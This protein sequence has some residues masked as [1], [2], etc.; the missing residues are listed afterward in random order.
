MNE[1]LSR[2]IEEFS[3]YLVAQF[4][5]ISI[6]TVTAQLGENIQ[7]NF[8]SPESYDLMIISLIYR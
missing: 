2:C 5:A 1:M 8:D 4:M 7:L 3:R 6:L